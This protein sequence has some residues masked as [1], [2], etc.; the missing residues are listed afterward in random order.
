MIIDEPEV[1]NK[2]KRKPKE[3]TRI[4]QSRDRQLS[5]QDTKP[6]HIKPKKTTR[7]NK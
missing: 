1:F 3:G 6:R 2:G 7:K 4:G 5:A